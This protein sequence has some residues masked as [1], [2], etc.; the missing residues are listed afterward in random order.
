MVEIIFMKRGGDTAEREGASADLNC[1]W[2][3]EKGGIK[4]RNKGP[5]CFFYNY[6]PKGPTYEKDVRFP[7]F[8]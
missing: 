3:N 1:M 6:F 4:G 8:E 7:I 5:A 2:L